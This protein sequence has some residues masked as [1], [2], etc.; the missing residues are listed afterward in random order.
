M[1]ISGSVS[2]TNR[3][4]TV[5]TCFYTIRRAY[6]TRTDLC[7]GTVTVFHNLSSTTLA[8]VYVFNIFQTIL[9]KHCYDVA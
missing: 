5:L 7:Q 3:S 9:L 2:T 8:Y 1:R 6:E 4:G